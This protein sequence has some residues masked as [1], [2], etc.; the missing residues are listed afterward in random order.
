MIVHEHEHEHEHEQN[1]H[2]VQLIG[3]VNKKN[4]VSATLVDLKHSEANVLKS[5]AKSGTNAII[6][7]HFGL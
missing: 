3:V 6:K 1:A 5:G 7:F 2:G 4:A